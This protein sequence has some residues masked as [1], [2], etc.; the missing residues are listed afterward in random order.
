MIGPR[1]GGF[2]HVRWSD[3]FQENG[4]IDVSGLANIL[5]DRTP[6]CNLRSLPAAL[7]DTA[8]LL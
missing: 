1:C 2:W 4:V 3:G 5:R 7:A 6:H 8:R